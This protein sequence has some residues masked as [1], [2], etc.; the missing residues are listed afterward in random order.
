MRHG[1]SA[2]LRS[3]EL[4]A[5]VCHFCAHEC[6][7]TLQK[8]VVETVYSNENW[9]LLDISPLF[10]N[11]GSASLSPSIKAV[12][13]HRCIA[14]NHDRAWL[15][16][17][18]SAL[19]DVQ[20]LSLV[21]SSGSFANLLDRLPKLRGF[22]CL[23]RREAESTKMFDDFQVFDEL[24]ELSYP[25]D[26]NDA[27]ARLCQ[28]IK[29]PTCLLDDVE[30]DVIERP[31]LVD[32]R[33]QVDELKPFPAIA[34]LLKNSKGRLVVTFGNL[35][36]SSSVFVALG[37]ARLSTH[38]QELRIR[39]CVCRIR[40]S[41]YASFIGALGSK[42][43]LKILEFGFDASD[44]IGTPELSIAEIQELVQSNDT[45]QELA[46]LG[47]AS[48]A[49]FAVLERVLPTLETTN[50]S[51][52][53][54]EFF[55]EDP[56]DV[57]PRIRDALLAALKTN[58]VMYQFGGDVRVPDDDHEIRHLLKQ[59]GYGRRLL[60]PPDVRVP[61]GLWATIFARIAQ[62]G[63]RDVMYAFVRSKVASLLPPS[64]V[65]PADDVVG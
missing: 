23:F 8:V 59:N 26:T 16:R 50:R 27:L 17:A 58:G 28:V 6:P 64:L 42:P 48:E 25:L 30:L 9:G 11:G 55:G 61:N 21:M 2:E 36:L 3:S 56:A 29:R 7:D 10:D 47:L 53:K 12:Q 35:S 45:L 41:D 63:E 5:D 34:T 57:W 37:S 60:L 4:L 40:D 51:L 65:P 15:Y 38:L 19:K 39:F 32:G 13:F 49:V 24:P 20:R 33:V 54:L 22:S 52:R 14:P 62:D 44:K 31:T 18:A 43:S 46:I 1:K